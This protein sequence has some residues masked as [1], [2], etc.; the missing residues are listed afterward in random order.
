M[1]TPFVPETTTAEHY[2]ITTPKGRANLFKKRIEEFTKP[3]T[4]GGPGLTTDQAIFEMRTSEKADDLALLAGM[5]DEPSK[6]RTEKLRQA[7][8]NAKLTQL[9]DENARA[10]TPSREV[11][12]AMRLATN[13]RSA[14]F[15]SRV[16]ELTAKGYTIDQAIMHMRANA[17]DA[18]LLA[19]MGDSQC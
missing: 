13:A 8:H 18:R 14:A 12:K 4:E 19:S 10:T 15:Q 17:A 5:G 9:A 11:A 2:D 7:K 6:V 1:N 3:K 16:D